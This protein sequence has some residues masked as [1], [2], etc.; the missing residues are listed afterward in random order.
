MTLVENQKLVGAG[1]GLRRPLLDQLDTAAEQGLPLPDFL[2]VAPENWINVGGRLGKRFRSVAERYPIALHGLSLDIGGQRPLDIELLHAIRA[3]IDR[4]DC[5]LY[6]EHLTYCADD[7]HL[8]DLLPL[9]FTEET[10]R[11]V[12]A[13]ARQVQDILGCRIALENASYYSAPPGELTEAEFIGAVLDASDCDLLL[14]VNNIVVNGANHGYAPL[15]FLNE[16]PLGRARYLHVAGH[17]VEASDLLIDT[18]G[19]A[20]GGAAWALLSEVYERCG[21]LP[22]LVE[23][24]F[25]FPRIAELLGEVAQVRLLQDPVGRRRAMGGS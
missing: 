21:A 15:T 24:D 17:R 23:R 9:P 10:V 13:R 16:L 5:P 4:F 14:D 19:T 1:L 20:I 3:F 6:S 25:N 2:E 12:A 22:T 7:G 18:H 8:Y 11:H